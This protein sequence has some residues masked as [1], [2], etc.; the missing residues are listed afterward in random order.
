MGIAGALVLTV[1]DEDV[2]GLGVAVF[3]R[4]RQ[5]SHSMTISGADFSSVSEKKHQDV[6]TP[7]L[8]LDGRKVRSEK[9]PL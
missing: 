1:L 9:G 5:R 8:V 3:S 6:R 2:Q 4:D 7:H